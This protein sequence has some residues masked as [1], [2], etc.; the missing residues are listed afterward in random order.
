[1]TRG[2]NKFYSK[3]LILSSTRLWQERSRKVTFS[4][5]GLEGMLPQKIG[6]IIEIIGGNNLGS[7][8][9]SLLVASF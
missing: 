5:N 1:M 8:R 9:R 2:F 7:S 4:Y 6:V 3:R